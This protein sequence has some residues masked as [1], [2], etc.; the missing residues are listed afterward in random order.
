[1]F[2]LEFEYHHPPSSP[3]PGDIIIYAPSDEEVTE[4]KSLACSSD[5]AEDFDFQKWDL[6]WDQWEPKMFDE[7][8]TNIAGCNSSQDYTLPSSE[9]VS[10]VLSFL[11]PSVDTLDSSVHYHLKVRDTHE[12]QELGDLSDDEDFCFFNDPVDYLDKTLVAEMKVEK[13]LGTGNLGS[14]KR[15]GKFRP[16]YIQDL[17]VTCT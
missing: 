16:K 6:A 5:E 8:R 14:H 11:S 4:I 17:N 15:A 1:M 10:W 2:H 9:Q 12:E 13:S 3:L 7:E